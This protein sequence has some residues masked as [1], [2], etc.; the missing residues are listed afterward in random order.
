VLSEARTPAEKAAYDGRVTVCGSCVAR[1]GGLARLL[2]LL[3]LAVG[4]RS[5]HTLGHVDPGSMGGMSSMGAAP[6]A[7]HAA[8]SAAGHPAALLAGGGGGHRLPGT[9]PMSMCLA[10]LGAAGLFVT[11]MMALRRA[12]TAVA[13]GRAGL[14]GGFAAG[15]ASIRQSCF[16]EL[17][18]LRI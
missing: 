16:A 11:C 1:G 4:V 12:R 5:M 2:F 18:V 17:L 7:A 13:L 15:Q 9:E 14:R 8:G 10:I 3:L 6:A